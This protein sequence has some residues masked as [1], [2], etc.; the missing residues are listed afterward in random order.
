M[1][2]KALDLK[3]DKVEKE[4]LFLRFSFISYLP[5]TSDALRVLNSYLCLKLTFWQFLQTYKI[6]YFILQTFSDF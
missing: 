3:Y 4:I 6:K 5:Y 2:N 1:D